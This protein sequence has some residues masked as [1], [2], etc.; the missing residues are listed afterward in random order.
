MAGAVTVSVVPHHAEPAIA[1]TSSTP[2]AIDLVHRYALTPPPP[3][4]P[5]RVRRVV[6]G[7]CERL[8]PGLARLQRRHHAHEVRLRRRPLAPEPGRRRTL[9]RRRQ[10]GGIGADVVDLRARALLRLAHLHLLAPDEP[11]DLGARIV[12]IAG[13]DGARGAHDHARGLEP[14]LQPVRAVVAL[15]RGVRVRVDVERVVGAALHAGLAADAARAIE[16]H[17]AVGAAV[18]GDGRTDRHAGRVVAVIAAQ[19]GEVAARVRPRPLLDVLDPGAKGSERHLVF[20]LA[21]HRARMAADALAV[22]DHETVS[23]RSCWGPRYG[24]PTPQ[25]SERPGK[26]WRSSIS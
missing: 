3:A 23:H 13:D 24:P 11:R 15:G 21:R 1:E 26:P 9:Q 22:V 7:T 10:R 4:G 8:G 19:H 25:R 12:E 20:F 18:E 14:D 17:D 6:H 16:V 2:A 5:W